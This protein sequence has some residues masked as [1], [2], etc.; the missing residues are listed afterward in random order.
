MNS[1]HRTVSVLVIRDATEQKTRLLILF[2]ILFSLLTFLLSC[3]TAPKKTGDVVETRKD[4]EGQLEQ[5]TGLADRGNYAA[6]LVFINEAKRLAVITDNSS[7]LIRSGLSSGNVLF[8]LGDRQEALKAWNEALKEAEFAGNTELAAVCRLHITR[9]NLMMFEGATQSARDDIARDMSLIKSDEMYIAFAW[10]V[11]GLAERQLN[12]Y[13]AAEEAVKKALAIHVKTVNFEL[14]AYD[15]FMI[16]SFRS[17]SGNYAGALTALESAL[18]YDR[19]TE[20]SWGIANDWQAIGD[21]RKKAG[22]REASAAAYERAAAI[23]LALGDRDAAEKALA[24][25]E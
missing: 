6:A 10:T 3:S 1:D 5:G 25:R 15:W 11:M 14:A 2:S 12:N 22:S 9:A 7:L 4:A 13:G 17:L 21:V 8:A 18:E 23:F 19:R 20:N 24:R 16:A